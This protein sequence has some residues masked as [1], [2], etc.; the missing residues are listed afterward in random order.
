MTNPNIGIPKTESVK[1]IK[2]RSDNP[3]PSTPIGK[4]DDDFLKGTCPYGGPTE[5]CESCS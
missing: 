1:D 2:A 4:E 5:S 3:P